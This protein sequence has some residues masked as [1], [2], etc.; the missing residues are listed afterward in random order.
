MKLIDAF[1]FFNELD[2]L[3]IR[4][5]YLYDIVDHF[6]LVEAGKTQTL[7]DKPFYYEENKARFEKYAKKIIHVKVE[8]YP[9]SGDVWSMEHYQRNCIS[10]GLQSFRGDDLVMISDLDE[11]PCKPSLC[12]QLLMSSIS[13]KTV[14]FTHIYFAY[15]LNLACLHKKWHGTVLTNVHDARSQSPQAF[16]NQKDHFDHIEGGWHFGWLNNF[17]GFKSKLISC[18]E[19]FNKKL[20]FDELKRVYD[21]HAKDGGY[22]VHSDNPYDM[23]V[24]LEKID[25]NLLPY[26]IVNNQEK[27]KHLLLK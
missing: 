13:L 26:N 6:I 18:V 15:Y 24:R 11:I 3:E 22:F 19:P 14:S 16:R 25:I 12:S 21:A 7:R 27:Y 23:S 1:P 8:D 17:E 20:D 5:E 10:R 4:L 2:L 9:D